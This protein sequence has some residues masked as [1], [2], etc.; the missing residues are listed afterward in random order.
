[1]KYLLEVFENVNRQG[2]GS[3]KYTKKA[4]D[5]IKGYLPEH[6]KILDIG[7]GKGSQT[8]KLAEIS[9]GHVTAIDN[10]PF[11]VD[12]INQKAKDEYIDDMVEAKNGDMNNLT[13]PERMYDVLWAEG[14]VYN[15]GFKKGLMELQK[16]VKIMGFMIVSEAVYIKDNPPDELKAFWNMEYPEITTIDKCTEIIEKCNLRI[17]SHFTLPEDGWTTFYYEPISE[18][19][20]E[21]KE[22]YRD[23]AAA[24]EEFNSIQNEIDI[25]NKYKDYFSYEYFVMKKV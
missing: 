18:V 11:F 4:Y 17:I 1:M 21:F 13:E 19:I 9:N 2:P 25:Y 15:M 20:K 7:S 14:S 22:K 16:F 5:M 24:I 3:N 23:N 12:F 6:P 10:H 8:F